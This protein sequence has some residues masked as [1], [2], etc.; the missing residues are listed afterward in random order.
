MRVTPLLLLLSAACH[1]A[2]PDSPDPE[3]RVVL[4][5]STMVPIE[6]DRDGRATVS[7]TLNGR[8]PYR[9]AVETGSPEVLLSSTVVSALALPAGGEGKGFRLDSLR[10]GEALVRGLVVGRNDAFAPLGVDGVLGLDAYRDLL[11]TVDYPGA[12]LALS[13]GS[14]SAPDGDQVLRAVRVGPF[15]GVEL[16]VGEVREIGVIDT[17]GGVGFQALPEVATRFRF[18]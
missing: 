18:E 2:A 7:V 13:R 3:E 11:L 14:L 17:Q 9:L 16:S 5:D 15:V 1:G 8:G 4:A 12:R 6:V 10:I